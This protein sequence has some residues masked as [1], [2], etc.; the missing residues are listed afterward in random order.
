VPTRSADAADH[1]DADPR[2][3][4]ALAQPP[5]PV[6]RA[7]VLAALAGA[8]VFAGISAVATAEEPAAATGLRAESA[9]EMAV[10]LLE[11]PDGSRALPVFPDLGALRRFRLGARPVPLTGPQACA[12][13]RDEGATALLV[14]PGGAAVVLDAIELAALADGWVPITGTG[15]ASRRSDSELVAATAGEPMIRALRAALAG[16]PLRSARILSG[17]DGLVLGVAPHE[18]LDAPGLAA[19]ASRVLTRLGA[20][21]PAEGMDLTQVPAR[22][23]GQE[24]LQRGWRGRRRA[25]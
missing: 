8:R 11:A 3:A 15:L 22:G 16:E 2:L 19:L 12:A 21:L 4:E 6:S 20:D 13:A 23:P 5:S 25:R 17:P 10:L 7:E 9:A 18:P 14:D 24:V 1:G